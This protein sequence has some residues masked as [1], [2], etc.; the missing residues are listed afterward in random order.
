MDP[1]GMRVKEDVR[2]VRV[3]VHYKPDRNKPITSATLKFLAK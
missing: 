2:S 3:S 1:L